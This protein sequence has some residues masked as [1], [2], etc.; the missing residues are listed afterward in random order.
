MTKIICNQCGGE[1][2]DGGNYDKATS[3]LHEKPLL[4]AGTEQVLGSE[5]C[6]APAQVLGKATP[7]SERRTQMER[8]RVGMVGC[9]KA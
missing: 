4:I 3:H 1:Y 8:S 5:V 6:R 7:T 2:N 9:L